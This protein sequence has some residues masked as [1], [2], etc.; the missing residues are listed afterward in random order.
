[1][2]V[3]EMATVVAIEARSKASVGKAG[4]IADTK[5][6]VEEAVVP[7]ARRRVAA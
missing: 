6:A 7:M 5:Q 1:M 2:T 4:T 3:G